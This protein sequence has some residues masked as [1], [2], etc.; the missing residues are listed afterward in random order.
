MFLLNPFL[1]AENDIQVMYSLFKRPLE[2]SH[3]K[4]NLGE[5]N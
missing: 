1:A 4:N 3:R 2:I 5:L